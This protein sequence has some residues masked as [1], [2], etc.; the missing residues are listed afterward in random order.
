MSRLT[1]PEP[2]KM[3][4]VFGAFR[5]GADEGFVERQ[6][7]EG[8][9]VCRKGI[10][11]SERLGD[12]GHQFREIERLVDVPRHL[13]ARL[14]RRIGQIGDALPLVPIERD[15]I[16]REDAVLGL[17]LGHHV[18]HRVAIRDRQLLFGV[19]ELDAH[20]LGLRLAP[21]PQQR[22]HH[23]LAADPGPQ[24]SPEDHPPPPCRREIDVAR[25][26][27]EAKLR[28]AHAGADG[29]VGPI[30]AAMRVR[31]RDE[32]A[33]YDQALLGKIEMED[34]IARRR[35]IR[36]ADTVQR[37]EI[38][39]DRR[40]LVVRVPPGKHEVIVCDR[41]LPGKDGVA[42]RDLVEGMN[43]KRRRAI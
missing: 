32:R 4:K 33:R 9:L 26:P 8:D 29:T 18:R 30:G 15:C 16:R 12:E 14:E 7:L 6:L 43:R 11:R 10:A 31:T 37:R 35:V 17:G 2:G 39:P 28:A 20:A 40:L 41:S 19:D 42:A 21:S 36:L 25:R 38:A 1:P 3:T 5:A 23:V 27:A 24:P 22:Q 34:P 13:V